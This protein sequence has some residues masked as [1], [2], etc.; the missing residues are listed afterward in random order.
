MCRCK[1]GN[2]KKASRF[3][4]IR[5]QRENNVGS[6]IQRANQREKGHIKD[7]HC[8]FCRQVT[9]NLELRYCDLFE[10][11]MEKATELHSQYY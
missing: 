3:I 8:V 7:L 6:G 5:C 2:P 10:D 11:V 9:K 4:C 1:N